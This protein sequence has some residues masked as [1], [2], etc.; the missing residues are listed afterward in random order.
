MKKILFATVMLAAFVSCKKSTPKASCAVTETSIL[1]TYKIESYKDALNTDLFASFQSC[2]KDDTY[3]FAA[4]GVVNFADA[5]VS[6]MGMPPGPGSNSW[7]L[8]TNN[9][10]IMLDIQNSNFPTAV[11]GNFNVESFDC[12]HLVLSITPGFSSAG[13]ETITFVK[14]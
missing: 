13:K 1:G 6:C 11:S 5:G 9:T 2:Q 8:M 4:S 7:M 14:Q 3:Q 10:V 12:S